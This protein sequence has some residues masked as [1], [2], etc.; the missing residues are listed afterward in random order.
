MH[1]AKLLLPS[2]LLATRAFAADF[3]IRNEAE[4]KLCVPANTK[5]ERLGTDMKFLEG[6]QWVPADGGYL[7]FSDIPSNELK[8]WTKAGG[9]TT[10]RNPSQNANGNTLDNSGRLVTA[11]HSGRRISVT[12]KDGTI[13]TVVDKFEGKRLNSPNDVV[14]KG[15]GSL[16]FTDPDYGLPTDPATKQKTGKEQPG[17][18]VYRF[19]PMSAQL[20]AVAKDFDKPN[21]LCFSPDEKR[22]YVADSGAPKHIRA[23][24][25]KPDGQLANGAVFA[26]IDK[27]AP[28]GI[29]CDTAG[30]VWSSAADGVHIYAPSGEL[31][32]KIL[33]P[34]SPANLAFGGS[35]LKTLYITARK[36]LY[37]IPVGV[38]GFR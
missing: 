8:K 37:A 19:D 3:E 10:F 35:D 23:F 4:F 31:I 30:R 9:V 12:E 25:V 22:L 18:Y 17:N 5:V 24:D 15:D 34:E 7:V 1:T 21:G 20:T 36:S 38:K 6:P 2:F 16:W 33:V 14:V 28:D 32:G 11:E 29:R 27:G 26:K 13:K